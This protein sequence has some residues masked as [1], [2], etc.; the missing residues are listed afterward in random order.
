MGSTYVDK[1]EYAQRD[2]ASY[3]DKSAAVVRSN[4]AWFERQ[5]AK[6]A[7]VYSVAS[8]EA[9]PFMSTFLAIFTFLSL[10]PIISF[11]GFSLFVVASIT[12]IASALSFILIAI[13]EAILV[14][15]LAVILTCLFI[16][17]LIAT[18]TTL[19]GY[20]AFTFV[21]HVR[22]NGRA[23]AS[24][25]ATKTRTHFLSPSKKVKV[26]ETS[27]GSEVSMVSGSVGKTDAKEDSLHD[28]ATKVKGDWK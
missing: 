21:T 13:I 7:I 20:L 3:F 2:L 11:L 8:F 12:F 28:D 25:W 16:V 1:L 4:F 15:I 18:P 14:T 26:G 23:G 22:S 9:H 10:L 19:S 24:Q 27:E 17:A 5:F 6:P